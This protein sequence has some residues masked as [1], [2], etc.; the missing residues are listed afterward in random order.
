MFP[1][2]FCRMLSISPRVILSVKV[3][4]E[5][6]ITKQS[7]KYTCCFYN[8]NSSENSFKKSFQGG[9]FVLQGLGF[10]PDSTPNSGFLLIRTL[11][12]R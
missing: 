6:V 2:N 11:G 9:R 8:T 1:V 3:N 4:N 7:Q 12:I 10:S 5:K